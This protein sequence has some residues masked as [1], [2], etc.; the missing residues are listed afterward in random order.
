MA[1]TPVTQ[2]RAPREQLSRDR[3]ARPKRWQAPETL[4]MPTAREGWAHRWVRVSMMG[5]ADPSNISA[6]FREGWEPCKAEDYPE[7][8]FHESPGGRFPGSVEIGGLLLCRIPAE[9]MEQRDEHYRNTN[10]NQMASVD[11]SFMRENDA[12]MPLFT[13]RKSSVTFGNGS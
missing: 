3:T 7:L 5:E 1:D 8:K 6:K 4:P 2:N 11:Q 13:E 10:Q 9:F 12:R